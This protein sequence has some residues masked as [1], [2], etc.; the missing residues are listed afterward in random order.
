MSGTWKFR[1]AVLMLGLGAGMSAAAMAVP[2]WAQVLGTDR[3]KAD[4]N[5]QYLVAEQDGP[6][7]IMACSFSGEGARQQAH[8]LVLELRKRYKLPAYSHKVQFKLDDPNGP[9]GPRGPVRWQYRR[10]AEHPE[11]GKDGAIQEYAVLVGNYPAINDPEARRD[12]Q[13]IKYLE[14]DCLNVD[15]GNPTFQTLAALRHIQEDIKEHVPGGNGDN[16]RKGPMGHA[17]ITTNPLLPS[18][19][20]APKGTVDEL[21]LRMNRG[22]THSLLDCQGKYTVQVAHFTGT[23][24]FDQR[25]IEA[26]A[27]GKRQLQSTLTKAAQQAHDLTEALRM[28][29]YD[30]YEFHDRFSSIVTVGSFDSVGMPLPDGKVEIDPRVHAIMKVFGGQAAGSSGVQTV[31]AV[32][33]IPLDPQPLP[34]EVPKRSISRELA[35]RV[36]SGRR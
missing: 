15:R 30:A 26:L 19:Y 7:M 22:V 16:R 8:D 17:F 25:G 28:K 13:K 3:V 11:D 1:T 2:P 34:V 35:E 27:T 6:W 29:G 21:V 20:Y 5:Q 10:F 24:V 31:Q 36:D 23:T 33:G 32:V 9:G 12:L 14:P 18:D 4:P